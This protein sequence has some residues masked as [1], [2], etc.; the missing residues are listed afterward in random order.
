MLYLY[1]L[2][3]GLTSV[4]D[5]VG[6]CSERLAVVT[7][8][9]I[10]AVAGVVEHVPAVDRNRLAAQDRVVR[11]LHERAQALLPMRFGSAFPSEA[12]AARAMR[13]QAPRLRQQLDAVKGNE[14]MT[15]RILGPPSRPSAASVG[16]AEAREAFATR[17]KADALGAPGAASEAPGADY[18]RARAARQVPPEIQP[19]LLAVAPLVRATRVERG[20]TEGVIATVYHLIDRGRSAAYRTAMTAAAGQHARLSVHITGPSPCYAFS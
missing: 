20:K 4:D 8:D 14:Q 15:T 1:A 9:A 11:T 10:V 16:L 18:L 5:L 12:D 6:I 2:A 19:L 3:D 17:A 13:V 7:F